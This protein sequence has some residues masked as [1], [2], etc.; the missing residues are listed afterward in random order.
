MDRPQELIQYPLEPSLMITK[1]DEKYKNIINNG[2]RMINENK[3]SDV[4]DFLNITNENMRNNFY[5]PIQ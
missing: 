5:C 4:V 3:D 1:K 2:I